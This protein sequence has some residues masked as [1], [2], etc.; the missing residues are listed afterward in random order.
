MVGRQPVRYGTVRQCS[1]IQ[2][3]KREKTMGGGAAAA[4]LSRSSPRVV[5]SLIAVLLPFS[6]PF[7]VSCRPWASLSAA[8]D[9]SLL[10]LLLL[11]LLPVSVW[12]GERREKETGDTR[13]LFQ[14]LLILILSHTGRER[15]RLEAYLLHIV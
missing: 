13:S 14:P 5:S 11:L 10:L 2:F 8:D 12:R 1:A 6:V 3:S 9:E 7:S 15:E 4:G